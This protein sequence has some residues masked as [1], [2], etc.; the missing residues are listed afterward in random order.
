MSTDSITFG[1]TLM[2]CMRAGFPPFLVSPRNSPEVIAGLLD[3]AEITHVF[4]SPDVAT[5]KH[6]KAGTAHRPIQLIPLPTLDQLYSSDGVTAPP[7]VKPGFYDN[8]LIIHSSGA[9]HPRPHLTVSPCRRSDHSL[10]STSVPK[11]LPVS[12]STLFLMG[13]SACTHCFR[14]GESAVDTAY[15]VERSRLGQHDD[16]F[17]TDPVSAS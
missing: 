1:A 5:T 11:L 8:A 6:A 3:K 16:E 10:G 15:R 13:A 2:G 4:Y 12:H 14:Q 17:R 7:P 9:F